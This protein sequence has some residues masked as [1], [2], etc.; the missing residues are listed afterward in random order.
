MSGRDGTKDMAVLIPPGGYPVIAG[1]DAASLLRALRDPAVAERAAS[2]LAAQG[3][4]MRRAV[5]EH[6]A[7]LEKAGQGG[8]AGALFAEAHEIRGLAG[9]AGLGATGRIANGLCRYLDALS[10]LNAAADSSLV[11]LHLDAIARASR[12]EDEATRLGEEVAS[13][14]AALVTRRLGGIKD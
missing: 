1:S 14:L 10:H 9:N 2:T 6:V 12:A 3:E 7:R 13:E 4:T 11:A 5:L 8:D